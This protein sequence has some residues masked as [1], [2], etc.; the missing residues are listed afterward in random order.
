MYWFRWSHRDCWLI[1]LYFVK[2]KK[3]PCKVFQ[4]NKPWITK[5]VK[6]AV[7]LRNIYYK[8]W[9]SVQR[10]HKLVRNEVR[11]AKLRYKEKVETMF[12]SGESHLAWDGVKSIIGTKQ[13]TKSITLGGKS[14]HEL[15]DDLNLFFTFLILMILH[16]NCRSMV[17]ILWLWTPLLNFKSVKLMYIAALVRLKKGKVQ[18]LIILVED[19]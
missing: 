6:N 18:A 8:W 14:D 12:K 4:N 5:H 17:G 7:N 13:K 11:L 19:C 3:K 9:Y 16:P 10:A 15:A 1:I 2:I